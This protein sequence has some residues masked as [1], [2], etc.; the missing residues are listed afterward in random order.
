MNAIGYARISRRSRDGASLDAQERAIR[1]AA[2]TRGWDLAG[3]ER[4]VASAKRGA[5]RPGLR[6]TLAAVEDG[7]D[8]LIVATLDRLSRSVLDFATT[9]ERAQREGWTL[10]VLDLGLDLSTPQGEFTAHVLSAAAQ[11]ERRLISERTRRVADEKRR[12]GVRMGRP[13]EIDPKLAT[14]IRRMHS[15]GRSLKG[16]ADQL[17]AEGTPTATGR[18]KWH[19]STIR[20]IVRGW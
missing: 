6:R 19:A 10:V 2:A 5:K 9:V 11:L 3:V 20:G 16:I 18:G 8:A 12:Q 13:P 14:R 15:H 4:E 1:E 17:N 7:S